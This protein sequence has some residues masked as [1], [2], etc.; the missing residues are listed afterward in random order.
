[1]PVL[2][3]TTPTLDDVCSEDVEHHPTW[4]FAL[5]ASLGTIV[6]TLLNQHV[7]SSAESSPTGPTADPLRTTPDAKDLVV[8][9]LGFRAVH[10][11]VADPVRRDVADTVRPWIRLRG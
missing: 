3:D 1:M 7:S 9:R 4:R 8:C 11:G 2:T 6:K 10:I 5:L